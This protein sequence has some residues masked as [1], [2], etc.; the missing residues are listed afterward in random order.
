MSDA[1]QNGLAVVTK[2]WAEEREQL[3]DVL[4]FNFTGNL[5]T[6]TPPATRI[7]DL[8]EEQP[9]ALHELPL[10]L[11]LLGGAHCPFG[12]GCRARFFETPVSGCACP[13]DAIAEPHAQGMS[14]RRV[15]YDVCAQP[16]AQDVLH[17]LAGR[18]R[19]LVVE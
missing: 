19:G 9:V 10:L 15:R 1:P 2:V 17:V 14:C 18:P 7:S 16:V 4:I 8:G 13:D 6:L 3:D 11:D 12:S 5:G